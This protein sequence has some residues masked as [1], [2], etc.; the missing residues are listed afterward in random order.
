MGLFYFAGHGMQVKGRNYL[1]PV[2]ADLVSEDEVPY[3]TLDADAV[4]AKMESA[5][6][7]LN[8]LILDAC[9]NNPFGSNARGFSQGLAQMDAPAGS[10]I[11]G[12]FYFVPGS[13][14]AQ[15][16][17]VSAPPV[18]SAPVESS[19]STEPRETKRDGRFI[20]YDNRTVLDTSTNLMWAARDNGS[21]I[22]WPKA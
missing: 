9:R 1:V 5:R 17:S 10:S 6:N 15:A 20:A 11:T 19:A 22:D 16:I 13:G 18:V 2:D 8:I 7:R 3:N 4:L 12:D 14:P 21:N